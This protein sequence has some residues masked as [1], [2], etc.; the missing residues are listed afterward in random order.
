MNVDFI[1]IDE[2][3][4]ALTH[5]GVEVLKVFDKLGSLLRLAAGEELF[6]LFPAPARVVQEGAQG[7]ATDFALKFA[8]HP[9]AQFLEVP[10]IAW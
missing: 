3:H 5:A 2:H 6:A 9:V 1:Q 7:V 8:F 10:A 4:F